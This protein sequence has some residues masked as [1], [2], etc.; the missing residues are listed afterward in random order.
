MNKVYEFKTNNV[1]DN[2]KQ[3]RK[4]LIVLILLIFIKMITTI[5]LILLKLT[6]F[7]GVALY[8]WKSK[9]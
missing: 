7:V 9:D 8:N 3:I 4:K 6:F 2:K 1:Q 5:I